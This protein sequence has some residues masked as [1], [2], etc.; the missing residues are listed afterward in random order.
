MNE[1][2]TVF[3]SLLLKRARAAVKRAG[4]KIG[5][6][7]TWKDVDRTNPWFEVWVADKNYAVWSGSASSAA[8]AK[9]NYLFSLLPEGGA[10]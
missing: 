6:L 4:I 2:N 10:E 5:K 3:T 7:T 8:E 9:A 1:A